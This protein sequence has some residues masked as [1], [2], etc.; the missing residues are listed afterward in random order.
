MVTE[1]KTLHCVLKHAERFLGSHLPPLCQILR[2]I[3]RK[4]N[5]SICEK[6]FSPHPQVVQH[7][8]IG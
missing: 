1:R 8:A 4:K 2:C 7:S 6:A 5:S 3:A